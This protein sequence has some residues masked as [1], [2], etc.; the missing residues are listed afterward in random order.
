M[1]IGLALASARA[2]GARWSRATRAALLGDRPRCRDVYYGVGIESSAV[3]AHDV[4][5]GATF[6]RV[7]RARA[8]GRPP[9]RSCR[10]GR[11]GRVRC[12]S[13][14][15][16]A[17]DRAA[18]RSRA[19]SDRRCARGVTGRIP[20]RVRR[21]S[22]AALAGYELPMGLLGFPG[23]AGSS[24]ASRSRLVLLLG[25][26]GLDWAVIPLAF[27]PFGEGPL[28]QSVGRSSSSG[29]R[30][31]AR[32]DAHCSTARTPATVCSTARRPPRHGDR[33]DGA[34]APRQR[35]RRRDRA[36]A[37]LAAVRAR[38]RG[39]GRQLDPVRLPDAVYTRVI[40]PVPGDSPWTGQALHVA[41]IRR[42]TFPADALRV[43]AADV[44]ALVARAAAVDDPAAYGLFDLDGSARVPFACAPRA[45]SSIARAATAASA[46]G[47][48]CSSPRTKACS[49]AVTS[50]TSTWSRPGEP[51]T[52]VS[53]SG[54]R[55]VPQ[56]ADSL[57]PRC[58]RSR[59]LA[60]RLPPGCVRYCSGRRDR[61]RSG[62]S[63][64][65]SSQLP[66]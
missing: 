50:R 57:P 34:T 38:G 63:A 16:L 53:S 30:L 43:H 9:A 37:R 24:R 2:R 20:R 66:Q 12:R 4:A 49:G 7:A 35:R 27:S 6:R 42:A 8:V 32:L 11:A 51:V 10:A 17:D 1:L 56:L 19:R 47:A 39:C 46:R 13:R 61:R 62:Q 23:S 21:R 48:T 59:R 36:S 65:P 28:S 14:G 52:P 44:R 5:G 15:S 31:H 33:G 45:R 3:E 25:G 18:A 58:R 55:L 60:V 40:G 22:P 26:P 64:L 54:E 29:S 41:A